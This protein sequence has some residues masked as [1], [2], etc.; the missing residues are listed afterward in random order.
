[1]FGLGTAVFT[2]D[3][4]RGERVARALE[5]GSTFVNGPVVSDPRLPFGGIKQ[6][7]YG[8]ELGSYGIKEF[9]NANTVYLAQVA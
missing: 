2:R 8:G 3:P 4:D 5:A 9:V 1:V 7:G 6:S